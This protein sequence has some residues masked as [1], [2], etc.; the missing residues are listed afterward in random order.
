[1]FIHTDIIAVHHACAV[2]AVSS[3]GF[4]VSIQDFLSHLPGTRSGGKGLKNS[5]S[6]SWETSFWL[7]AN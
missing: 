3:L 4:D 2:D 6:G 1:M 5:L 7:G